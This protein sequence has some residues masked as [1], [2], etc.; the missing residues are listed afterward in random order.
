MRSLDSPLDLSLLSCSYE[1][2]AESSHDAIL[3][4]VRRIPRGRVATYGQV[5]KLAGFAR[6]PRLA[7]YALR[8]ADDTVPWQRVVN[9][10]GKISPRADPDS[11]PRQRR[12]LEAEGIRFSVTGVIDLKRYQWRPRMR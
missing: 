11:I 2:M 3:R 10:A 1:D 12:M 7:G 9:A 5:S 6:Q 8:H 4:I